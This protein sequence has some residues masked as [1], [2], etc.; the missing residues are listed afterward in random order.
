MRIYTK[1]AANY[2]V[3][4][5]DIKGLITLWEQ[6]RAKNPVYCTKGELERL[7]YCQKEALKDSVKNGSKLGLSE[8][9]IELVRETFCIHRPEYGWNNS[10]AIE[11]PF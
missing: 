7:T 6:E 5:K 4:N 8:D 11:Y 3:K 1:K 9:D 10:K 2:F